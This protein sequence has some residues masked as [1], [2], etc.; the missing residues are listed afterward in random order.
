VDILGA[1][2]TLEYFLVLL[3]FMFRLH[4]SIPV[5]TIH[6]VIITRVIEFGSQVIGVTGRPLTVGEEFGFQATGNG[7]RI[8]RQT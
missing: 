8:D 3:F 7:D 1:I 6:Q 5:T 4:R 2:P